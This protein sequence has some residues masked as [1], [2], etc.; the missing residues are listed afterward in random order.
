[1]Q[2]IHPR[3]L[4]FLFALLIPVIVHLFNFRRYKTIFF[5]NTALLKTIE[6][7][8]RKT[9]KIK[10]LLVLLFRM[11]C[12]AAAVI[13]FAGPYIAN[14]DY[15]GAD[16]N[17]LCGIYIDNSMS[18]SAQADGLPLIE[19]AR[20]SAKEMISS[21]KLSDK[22][23]L[24][25]NDRNPADE[26]PMN[27]AETAVHIDGVQLS[28]MPMD[29]AD[30]LKS[31]EKIK[32]DFGFENG[33]LFLFSDFQENML[34]F[35]SLADSTNAIVLAQS[36][37]DVVSNI[38]IDSVWMA[39]P[40]VQ[41]GLENTIVARV[42]NESESEV[43]GL[44][45]MLALNGA[46]A[47]TVN[48]DIGKRSHVDVCFQFLPENE[49]ICRG[50]VYVNDYPITYDDRMFFALDVSRTISVLELV[51][52][53]AAPDNSRFFQNDPLFD[54]HKQNVFSVDNSSLSDFQLIIVGSE[55]NINSTMQHTLLDFARNGGSV[56]LCPPDLSKFETVLEKLRLYAGESDTNEVRVDYV[57]SK[58]RFFADVIVS[59]PDN[60]DLPVVKKHVGL[61]G[62]GV[63]DMSVL[64]RLQNGEPYALQMPY[65]KGKVYVFASSFDDRHTDFV[66]NSLYVPMLYKIAFISSQNDNLY[67]PVEGTLLFDMPQSV[68]PMEK[69]TLAGDD[70]ESQFMVENRFMLN[71]LRLDEQVTESGF[72]RIIQN[73]NKVAEWAFN[74]GREESV[75]RFA[76]EQM[77]VSRFRENGFDKVT[78]LQTADQWNS[79]LSEVLSGRR[80]LWP[81]FII[82]A[83]AAI[84]AEILI[85]RFW[86]Q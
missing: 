50:E 31:F 3:I 49:G 29:V 66:S 11:L 86:K 76:D 58:N 52:N 34:K 4:Y 55:K 80:M 32:K 41:K 9:K 8:E 62:K 83:L 36:L 59:V 75:M 39:A 20:S 46:S 63:N 43:K 72:Y 27:G 74:N 28:N 42:V 21:M 68:D 48:A 30:V 1:M 84:A 71:K 57:N 53:G 81:I 24:L 15:V 77:L 78:V 7:E 64:L 18:M 69:V 33:L 82:I 67:Y 16:D 73:G 85:L 37:P 25:T 23:V 17:R 47:G 38:Y 60:A 2:F 44:P 10:Q 26:F 35:Q 45:V 13:A 70:Y 40:V 54:Y 12:V 79:G 14:D 19:G 6:Q 61:S 5:S 22:F 65:G 56:V 51:D